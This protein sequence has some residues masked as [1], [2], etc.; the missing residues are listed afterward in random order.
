MKV[1]PVVFLDGGP[2]MVRELKARGHKVFLDMKW[3]DIPR[4]VAGAVERAADLGVDLVTVHALGGEAMLRSAV[5][6][7]RGRLRVAAVSVLTSHD[8]ESYRVAVGA[9]EARELRAEVERLAS[10]AARAGV[11]AVV[12]SAAEVESV[13][14][15]MGAGSWIVVPGIR[16]LG[17][18]SEDHAR[19][20]DP[21]RA[22]AA[23]ATHL[24]IGRPIIEA[25]DPLAV[26]Q[27]VC[28]EVS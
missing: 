2:A 23:G 19:S 8:E 15:V 1:G 9:G 18:D 27:K 24:V 3:H 26:Y 16:P 5:E 17:W 4:T 21:R 22:V 7:A 25:S 20:A 28:R 6:A 11:E 12:C 13:G 14:K 10:L